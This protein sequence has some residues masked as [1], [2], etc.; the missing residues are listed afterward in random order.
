MRMTVH[1]YFDDHLVHAATVFVRP[2]DG[3]NEIRSRIARS[4]FGRL[5]RWVPDASGVGMG[6]ISVPCMMPGTPV[7]FDAWTPLIKIEIV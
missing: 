2:A 6:Q 3:L 4:L 7:S 1:V 5:A